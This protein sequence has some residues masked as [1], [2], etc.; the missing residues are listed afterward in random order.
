MLP[1]YNRMPSRVEK[2]LDDPEPGLPGATT[3]PPTTEAYKSKL[4]LAA[5]GQPSIGVGAG[6]FGTYVGGSTSLYF[7]DML[8]NRNLALAIQ[9]MGELQDIAGQAIYTNLA[10]RFDWGVGASYIPTCTAATSAPS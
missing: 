8:G 3:P 9:A 1:P 10:K 2:I 4:S 6:R 5:V 7:T